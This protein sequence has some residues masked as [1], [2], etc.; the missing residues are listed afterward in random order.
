[1]A[2]SN[3]NIGRDLTQQL[4]A[5]S[6][7]LSKTA[8]DKYPSGSDHRFFSSYPAFHEQSKALSEEVLNT[9]NKLC[10]H[11]NPNDTKISLHDTGDYA[12]WQIISDAADH[13]IEMVDTA[14]DSMQTQTDNSS[15]QSNGI[16][17]HSPRS[18]SSSLK[19]NRLFSVQFSALYPYALILALPMKFQSKFR[20]KF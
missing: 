12:K 17:T 13:C 4:I 8:Q 3:G 7:K 18:A 16:P 10:N 6:V 11:L 20:W 15:L 9:L 5:K 14:L 1:M 19:S 2:L